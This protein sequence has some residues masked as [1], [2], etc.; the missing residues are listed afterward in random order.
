MP[1]PHS[2]PTRRQ[3][4]RVGLLVF[5]ATLISFS[6]RQ[7][8]AMLVDPI[9]QSLHVSD[10]AMSL[11]Y[12]FAFVILYSTAGLPIGRLVDRY[13][14][15]G[16]L[17][18]GVAIW[19]L[20][21]MACGLANGYWTLFAARIGV[22]VGE[23]CLTPL[24]CSLLADCFEPRARGRAMSFYLL[25]VYAGIALS[26]VA[27]GSL[28]EALLHHSGLPV[29][30]RLAPWRGV[31][32]VISLPGLLIAALALTISEPARQDSPP[33]QA[34]MAAAGRADVSLRAYLKANV[35][36]IAAALGAHGLLAF[37]GYAVMGWAPSM[38]MRDFHASRAF[39]G[40]ILGGTALAG[41]VGGA[42]AGALLCDRWTS[43]GVRAAK[44]RVCAVGAAVT[45]AGLALLF[46]ATSA[47]TAFAAVALCLTAI[48]F[49]SASGQVMVQE[50]FPNS[51]RGQGSAIMVLLMG[52]LGV[53]CGPLAVGLLSSHLF[54]ERGL[55]KAIVAAGLPASGGAVLC[56]W[57]GRERYE[58]LRRWNLRGGRPAAAPGAAI[59]APRPA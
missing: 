17:A 58:A 53:G 39:V 47:S 56:Y 14:R 28:Y 26:M 40:A 42:L 5:A 51:L 19:S 33:E 13:Q 59:S 1:I 44:F 48:P 57:V 55:V 32:I 22:G 15:R 6:D 25:G 16:L 37:A 24:A 45:G 18:A 12:G 9:R 35:L 30:G 11:L 49:A 52:L 43:T 27:G 34:V 31:F 2:Y 38:L 54:H 8:L 4:I 36:G 3:A 20:M 46:F 41:G 10:T 7:V 50:L 21:T 29:I 23:A